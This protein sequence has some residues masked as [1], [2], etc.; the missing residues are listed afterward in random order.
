MTVAYVVLEVERDGRKVQRDADEVQQ[1]GREENYHCPVRQQ[2]LEVR[3]YLWGLALD[4]FEPF[5][6]GQE[7]RQEK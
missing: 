5:P 1:A 3:E 6:R 7:R 2:V 4:R